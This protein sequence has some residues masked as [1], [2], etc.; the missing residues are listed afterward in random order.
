MHNKTLFESRYKPLL[1]KTACQSHG[2]DAPVQTIDRVKN[3]EDNERKLAEK[4]PS[5]HKE[6][7]PPDD[8]TEPRQK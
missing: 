7:S 2:I 3:L 5:R 8:G 4:K 1:Y 6:T